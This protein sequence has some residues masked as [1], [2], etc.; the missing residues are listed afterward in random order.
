MAIESCLTSRLVFPYHGRTRLWIRI[1]IVVADP[2]PLTMYLYF[3]HTNCY[4]K[5]YKFKTKIKIEVAYT[6]LMGPD[7]SAHEVDKKLGR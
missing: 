6:C 5:K 7:W 4:N 1:R 2:D 3:C